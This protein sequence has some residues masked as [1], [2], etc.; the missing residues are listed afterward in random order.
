[1]EQMKDG[2]RDIREYFKIEQ[3]N[4]MSAYHDGLNR[5]IGVHVLFFK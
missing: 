4:V 3:E 2:D 5:G 1:M